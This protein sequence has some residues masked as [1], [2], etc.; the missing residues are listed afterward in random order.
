MLFT[1][2]EVP[3]DPLDFD[4]LEWASP[5]PGARFKAYRQ[6]GK[7]LRLL[8][9]TSE[10]VEPHWCEKAHA[11]IVL[12]GTLEVDFQGEVKRYPEGAGLLIPAGSGHK[13][14][15]ATPVVRLFLVE[16]L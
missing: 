7:Q 8:E 13:A 2:A 1:Q 12:S 9:F 16:D 4:A 10:F 3:M 6:G 11:G 5:L 14:R 15:A